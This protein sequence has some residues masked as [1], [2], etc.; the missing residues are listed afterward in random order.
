MP[1][2]ILDWVKN[3]GAD[4]MNRLVL[5]VFAVDDTPPTLVDGEARP[6]RLNK[7]NGGIVVHIANATGAAAD[8]PSIVRGTDGVIDERLA[9]QETLALVLA[10]LQPSTTA[11]VPKAAKTVPTASAEPIVGVATPAKLVRVQVEFDSEK[12]DQ[13]VCIGDST[14]TLANG[15]QLGPGDVYS[16]AV[17]DA[18]K[19]F[20]IGSEAGL[21]LRIKVL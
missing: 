20:C 8:A 19:L 13:Y 11:G 7:D 14:V 1:N 16:E 17:D 10:L 5:P 4:Y 6:G 12:A 2:S 21:K 3:L 9:T 15:E 18:A